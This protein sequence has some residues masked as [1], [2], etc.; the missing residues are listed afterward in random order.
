M[1]PHG[2]VLS[3]LET[4]SYLQNVFS[5][6]RKYFDRVEDRFIYLKMFLRNGYSLLTT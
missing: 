2:T 5:E 4:D 3:K 6:N 1:Q